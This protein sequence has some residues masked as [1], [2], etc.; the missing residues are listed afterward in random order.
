MTRGG[1]V[2]DAV[3]VC[4][5]RTNRNAS[6]T[7]NV[8]LVSGLTERCRGMPGDRIPTGV[9][10]VMVR[11]QDVPAPHPELMR[12]PL[13]T[14]HRPRRLAWTLIVV[15]RVPVPGPVAVPILKR[16][17]WENIFATF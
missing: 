14:L 7:V 11:H 2:A 1:A 12:L 13:P 16:A 4:S 3:Q 10:S 8:F 9:R 6:R 17:A 15:R 5:W